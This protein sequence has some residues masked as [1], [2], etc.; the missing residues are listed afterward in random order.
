MDIFVG[1]SDIID[2]VLWLVRIVLMLGHV[3]DTQHNPTL[4]G[5]SPM[6]YFPAF[7]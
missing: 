4:L 1:F 5:L 7:P 3:G 2:S 6:L